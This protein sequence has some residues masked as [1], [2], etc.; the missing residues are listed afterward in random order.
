MHI[1]TLSGSGTL[2]FGTESIDVRYRVDVFKVGAL[3]EARGS[4]RGDGGGLVRA[5]HADG[6][7]LLEFED[8]REAKLIITQIGSNDE[9]EFVVSGPIA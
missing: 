3:K 9:A 7:C 2:L 8:G 5:F 6:H 1:E 4:L